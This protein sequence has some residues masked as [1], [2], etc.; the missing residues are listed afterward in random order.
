MPFAFLKDKKA[1][2]N[3]TSS[4]E[5]QNTKCDIGEPESY[6]CIGHAHWY[7]DPN[8]P[9]RYSLDFLAMDDFEMEDMLDHYGLKLPKASTPSA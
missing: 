5:S 6:P 1:F 7:D 8:G 4:L 3:W 2:E 9:Y